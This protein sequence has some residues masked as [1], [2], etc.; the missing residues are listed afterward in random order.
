MA[1]PQAENA[2]PAAMAPRA[3]GIWRISHRNM[4]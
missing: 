4:L 1:L 3:S 2:V